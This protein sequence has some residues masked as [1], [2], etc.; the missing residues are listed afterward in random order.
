M[1]SK[2]L[3]FNVN[4]LAFYDFYSFN[5][6]LQKNTT[7]IQDILKTSGLFVK[8]MFSFKII[9]YFLTHYFELLEYLISPSIIVYNNFALSTEP[10][11]MFFE[12]TIRSP[13]N[14]LS[15]LPI[16]FSVPN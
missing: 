7:C 8:F 1:S 15:I 3:L 2:N 11:S 16:V 5:F 6:F 12:S 13:Q 4:C 10:F 14:P 9:K